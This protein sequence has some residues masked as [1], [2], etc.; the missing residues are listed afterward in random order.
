MYQA[1]LS[2]IFWDPESGLTGYC[3]FDRLW[4]WYI[5]M[6]KLEIKAVSGEDINWPVNWNMCL[7]TF[8]K[9]PVTDFYIFHLTKKH[10]CNNLELYNNL[11][12]VHQN[13]CT[14]AEG[15]THTLYFYCACWKEL[16]LYF[17][18]TSPLIQSFLRKYYT[19]SPKLHWALSSYCSQSKAQLMTRFT[20][21]ICDNKR[22]LPKALPWC[23]P[24]PNAYKSQ[25]NVA[26]LT[27]PL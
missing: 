21:S 8:Y 11:V 26:C 2:C 12:P 15:L 27:H 13:Q 6:S 4:H 19:Q 22:A 24:T 14:L 17:P 23:T 3:L 1:I 7:G 16:L 10:P 25:I 5:D 20:Q 9:T 18:Y